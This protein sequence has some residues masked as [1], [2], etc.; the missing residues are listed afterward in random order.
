[1]GRRNN[2]RK[3]NPICLNNFYTRFSFE[4]RVFFFKYVGEPKC[5]KTISLF[6]C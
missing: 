6:A 1:M 3:L 4:E 5:G 2:G